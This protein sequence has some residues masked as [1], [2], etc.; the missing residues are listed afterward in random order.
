[1]F[2]KVPKSHSLADDIKLHVGHTLPASEVQSVTNDLTHITMEQL[3]AGQRYHT[4]GSIASLIFYTKLTCF[5]EGGKHFDG[6]AWGIATPGGGALIGDVYL[7]DG[8]TLERLYR[9]TS[10][11]SIIA[12]A[13]YTAIKFSDAK[14]NLLATF[15]A[16]SVSIVAGT[17]TG[18]GHWF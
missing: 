6:Q 4:T 1:M 13:A 5:I 12:L 9:D 17:V 16:G 3:K 10:K 2:D 18:D 11:F 7:E 8:V 14:G 15:H